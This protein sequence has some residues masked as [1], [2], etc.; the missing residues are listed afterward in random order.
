M[1]GELLIAGGARDPCL[2]VLA[3]ASRR[4][5]VEPLLLTHAPDAEPLVCW[6]LSRDAL[7]I[8]GKPVAP[9]GVFLR[10]DVFGGPAAPG[11]LDRA[12]AWYALA[13]GW[14]SSHPQVGQFNRGLNAH[15]GVKPAELVAAQRHGLAIPATLITNS[16]AAARDHAAARDATGAIAKP[17]A[18]GAYVRRL[19][20]VLGEFDAEAAA[21]PLPAIVQERLAYPEYRVFLIAGEP[22]VFAIR[23]NHLDYRPHADNAMDYLGSAPELAA[24]IAK[25]QALATAL[26]CDFCACDLKSRAGSAEP[27]FLE[28]NTGP[29]FAAFDACAGGALAEAMVRVLV[30]N[31][32]S[33]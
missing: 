10:Y 28:I 21:A 4:L 7:T 9:R 16:L 11:T 25:L 13:Q 20:R 3:A 15:A 22:H 24:T 6:D 29:M 33:G 26:G 2:P 31:G 17:V 27:V 23:S 19:D 30:G 5:G 14:A 12:G 1:A 8:D 32:T 18:G